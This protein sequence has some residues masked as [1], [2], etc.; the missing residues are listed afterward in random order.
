M[1]YMTNDLT[2]KNTNSFSKKQMIVQKSKRSIEKNDQKLYHI[3]NNQI[4]SWWKT[5]FNIFWHKNV[6]YKR[7]KKLNET[8]SREQSS[9][10]KTIIKQQ[11]SNKSK[12][13]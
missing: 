2:I 3:N 7:F 10:K 8:T 9:N 11:T 1:I 6:A 4:K 5:N 12:K 13:Q